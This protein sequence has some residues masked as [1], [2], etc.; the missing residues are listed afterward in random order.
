MSPEVG[1]TWI[2]RNHC[3]G[4]MS[5]TVFYSA[6]PECCTWR[7]VLGLREDYGIRS[8][9]ILTLG[10]HPAGVF[11]SLPELVGEA[12]L[13]LHPVGVAGEMENG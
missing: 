6:L 7:L 12:F 1:S 3:L 9:A 2:L 4:G 8:C 11:L 5:F 10:I 13:H